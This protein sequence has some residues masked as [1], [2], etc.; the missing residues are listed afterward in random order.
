ML[1][2]VV[3]FVAVLFIGLIRSGLLD[4]FTAAMQG[5]RGAD[6][7][8]DRELLSDQTLSVEDEGR[9]EVFKDYLDKGMEE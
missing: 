2:Y 9:L 8:K 6:Q 5:R 7:P 3:I 1:P 4:E